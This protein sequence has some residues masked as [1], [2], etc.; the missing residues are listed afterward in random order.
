MVAK[1][2][3][4]Q[5]KKA[6]REKR[7]NGVAWQWQHRHQNNQKMAAAAIINGIKRNKACSNNGMAASKSAESAWRK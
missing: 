5:R 3:K 4:N 1:N 2:E 7:N 6:K